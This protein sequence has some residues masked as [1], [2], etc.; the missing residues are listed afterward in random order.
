VWCPPF[1]DKGAYIRTCG[2]EIRSYLASALRDVVAAS[3]A[4]PGSAT[5][6]RL[7]W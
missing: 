2:P 3:F 1:T 7:G 5:E 6:G 4:T